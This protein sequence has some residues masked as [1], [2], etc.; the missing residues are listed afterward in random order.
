[1]TPQAIGA[2]GLLPLAYKAYDSIKEFTDVKTDTPSSFMLAI[3][4]ISVC[5]VVTA[6]FTSNSP[7]LMG[8]SL[9]T[10]VAAVAYWS[11]SEA[12]TLL[13][14]NNGVKELNLAGN[15]LTNLTHSIKEQSQKVEDHNKD[16]L[17][18]LKKTSDVCNDI[19]KLVEK[20]GTIEKEKKIVTKNLNRRSLLIQKKIDAIINKKIQ[21]AEV[22]QTPLIIRCLSCFSKQ[23]QEKRT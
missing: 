8:F 9:C 3:L 2:I 4:I 12:K 5:G 19:I 11:L 22:K 6:F 14:F 16:F 10:A 13:Q 1:M 7:A 20:L 17:G 18:D 15:N 23:V 21:V